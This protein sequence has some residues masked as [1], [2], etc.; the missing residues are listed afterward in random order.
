VTTR[1][2]TFGQRSTIAPARSAV[3][4][5]GN[6]ASGRRVTSASSTA[7]SRP[8]DDLPVAAVVVSPSRSAL[9]CNQA[10]TELT[11]LPARA[12]AGHG[13]LEAI[14]A[15]SFEGAMATVAEAAGRSGVVTGEWRL[16]D[17]DEE[18]VRTVHAR[19]SRS[20]DGNVLV[21]LWE[22]SPHER[23]AAAGGRATHDSVTGLL[24]RAALA[25]CARQS[26]ERLGPGSAQL[27][28]LLVHLDDLGAVNQRF[29]RLAGDRVLVAAAAALAGATRPDDRVAR[30]TDDSF[31]V[32]CEDT[33]DNEAATIALQLRAAVSRTINFG[34][35]SVELAATV[36]ASH[37][38]DRSDSFDAL[39][40]RA[41]RALFF[42]KR[43]RRIAQGEGSESTEARP[44]SDVRVLIIDDTHLVA[45]ALM[46]SLQQHGYPHV[47]LARNVSPDGVVS[48]AANFGPDV[49]L[50]DSELSGSTTSISLIR[51]LHQM[52]IVV[53]ML[54]STDEPEQ[55]ARS[56]EAGAVGI[57]DKSRALEDL[58]V[59][60]TDAAMG[61]TV[62]QPASRDALLEVVRSQRVEAQRR[63][64]PFRLLTGR[65]QAVLAALMDG[66]TAEVIGRDHNVSLS[67]I[68]TQIR[69]ILQKLGVKS[70]LAAVAL[71]IR[72]DWQPTN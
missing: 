60:L 8:L 52:G 39:V 16:A 42:S 11:G 1:R 10:W 24:N 31:A 56:L 18:R 35:L 32:L 15:N 27:A 20:G 26:L 53:V 50:V 33:N 62:L 22:M 47:A 64:A 67:T 72:A 70:Q 30:I 49:A 55:S 7:S 6:S 69:A 66:K 17:A 63:L 29:G 46:V 9:T 40:D 45:E 61:R 41:D 34:D 21:A 3:R 57:F 37:T 23:D 58:M 44:T 68:R 43:T 25:D 48:A 59:L 54:T 2:N 19:A 5:G 13:W 38:R 65:E 4:A 36:V 28:L 71:A 14:H 51:Q 12:T